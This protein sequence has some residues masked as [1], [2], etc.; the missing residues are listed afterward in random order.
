MKARVVLVTGGAGFIGTHTVLALLDAGWNV[1]V[2]DDLSSGCRD[3]LPEAVTFYLGNAGESSL[4]G[5]I[6]RRHGVTAV[7]HLAASI[8]APESVTYPLTYYR[9]N[10]EVSRAL[11]EVCTAERVEA[12]VFASSSA[13]YGE[14]AAETINE[15]V[16]TCPRTPYGRTK[17]VTEWMLS[18]AE[19]S[20]GPR[21]VA[22]RY[23]NVAGCDLAG[24]VGPVGPPNHL[25][26]IA[27]EVVQGL[28]DGLTL[29]GT[30]YPTP[31]GT[32]MRD[33]VHVSDVANLNV[34]ALRFLEGGGSSLVMNCGAGRG[35]SV[36]DVAA[37][38]GQI[39]GQALDIHPGPRRRGDPSRVVADI[40][41][42]NDA[43]GWR[44]QHSDLTTIIATELAW[45]KTLKRGVHDEA[46]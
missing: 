33:F 11:I 27:V 43:L 17:L 31:D 22:L 13:V 8:L 34:T 6:I 28:R 38:I 10:V 40:G 30:D 5:E 46:C 41:L 16:P 12:F 44:P 25:I 3:F 29:H 24:R 23:F 21:F 1:V 20:G 32:C 19:I 9:N 42:V 39:S 26:R 4:V 7:I 15:E 14:Q 45:Q 37:E 36:R 2:L 35:Y 18:D